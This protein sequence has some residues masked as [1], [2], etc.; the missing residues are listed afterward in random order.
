MASRPASDIDTGRQRERSALI[1]VDVQRDFLP[2]GALAVPRGDETIAP[3]VQ[4]MHAVDM[5]VLTADSHPPDHMSFMVAGGS[6]PT[7]CVAGTPGAEIDERLSRAAAGRGALYIRKGTRPDAEAYSAFDG[8]DR[9]GTPLAEALN[10]AGVGRL[11]VG[12]LATDYCVRATV[13]DALRDGFDV[14]VLRAAV[15]GVE[16]E[17]GDSER[18]LDE[19]RAAGAHLV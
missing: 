18:A 16:L 8:S 12:G 1:C 19:M 5:V 10:Q 13:L 17:P 9:A 6:W 7:H 14:T 11:T 3:L 15:R 2:G 4:A